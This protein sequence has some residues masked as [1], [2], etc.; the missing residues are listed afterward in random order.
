MSMNLTPMRDGNGNV[1]YHP[2]PIN[3][4]AL[5]PRPGPGAPIY[6]VVAYWDALQQEEAAAQ[7]HVIAF[8][9]EG[10]QGDLCGLTQTTE[11]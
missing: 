1:M 11:S 3:H 10:V 2:S 8:H 9:P 5:P 7:E 4:G 6:E